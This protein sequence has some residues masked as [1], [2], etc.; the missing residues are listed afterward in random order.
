[1]S[2][3]LQVKVVLIGNSGVGKTTL[4]GV[5][6][7]NG[8]EEATRPTI[9]PTFG[10]KTVKV[11]DKSVELLIWDTAGQEVYLS[12]TTLYFRDAQIAFVCVVQSDIGALAVWAKH[13]HE[14]VADCKIFAVLTKCDLLRDE[15]IGAVRRALDEAAS[16]L[17]AP[18]YLTS[19]ITGEG[20]S[21]LLDGAA[22]Q[23][24]ETA[25]PE[26]AAEAVCV[27]PGTPKKWTERLK[28]KLTE[29]LR[30]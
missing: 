2:D 13:V 30:C 26:I 11:D 4:A 22:R 18:I 3:L 28:G 1:M 25:P 7:G 5:V 20:V 24:L 6:L 16:S 12:V 27:D 15:A 10:R 21:A 14:V 29:K 23:S 17:G 9:L 19:A 8:V